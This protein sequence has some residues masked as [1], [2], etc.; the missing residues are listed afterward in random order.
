M[1]TWPDNGVEVR[2]DSEEEEEGSGRGLL[3][4]RPVELVLAR[5]RV[6]LAGN[7]NPPAGSPISATLISRN[8]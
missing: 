1:T 8:S 4:P 6:D 2:V 3:R 5:V 7:N